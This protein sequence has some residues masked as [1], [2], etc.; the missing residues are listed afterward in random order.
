[1]AGKP[2]TQ[3]RWNFAN[4]LEATIHWEVA[5]DAPFESWLLYAEVGSESPG[6]SPTQLLRN[7]DFIRIEQSWRLWLCQVCKPAST[8]VG[9]RLLTLVEVVH[10]PF[11][12]VRDRTHLA[13]LLL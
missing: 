10:G 11:D 8:S 9:N 3:R 2:W 4:Q 7:A 5:F 6:P 13:K 1:M 12:I